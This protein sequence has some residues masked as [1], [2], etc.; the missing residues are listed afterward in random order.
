MG[1]MKNGSHKKE[2]TTG[3]A[4]KSFMLLRL[5]VIFSEEI[6]SRPRLVIVDG[7]GELLG[8]ACGY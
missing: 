1:V 3:A 6:K 8:L 4:G 2:E 7:F 5:C